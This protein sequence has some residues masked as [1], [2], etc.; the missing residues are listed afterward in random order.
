MALN[1]LRREIWGEI[2]EIWGREIQSLAGK[3]L[4]RTSNLTW[5]GGREIWGQTEST[6]GN[7]GKSGDI[8]DK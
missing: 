3:I 8:H 1:H 4:I 6:P 5:R 2:W 7:P